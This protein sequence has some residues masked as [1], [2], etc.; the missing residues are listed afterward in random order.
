MDHLL[1]KRPGH[2]ASNG[3]AGPWAQP[4]RH[5]EPFLNDRW[6]AEGF[7]GLGAR[8]ASRVSAIKQSA[9]HWA[10]AV[11]TADVDVGLDDV[12]DEVGEQELHRH[13]DDRQDLRVGVPGAPHTRELGVADL[14]A[15]GERP[16]GRFLTSGPSGR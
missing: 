1:S 2:F 14:P 3:Q 16:G 13:R 7:T 11:S 9:V 10:A 15:A 8:T 4:V 6:V 12:V 5:V